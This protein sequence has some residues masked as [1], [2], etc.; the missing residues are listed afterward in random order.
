MNILFI[1]NLPL[2]GIT[3]CYFN[4]IILPINLLSA[5]D[6]F[7]RPTGSAL[8]AMDTLKR[9]NKKKGINV[10]I[11]FV[12]FE[13]LEVYEAGLKKLIQNGHSRIPRQLFF[14]SREQKGSYLS[15]LSIQNNSPNKLVNP[16]SQ[17]QGLNYWKIMVSL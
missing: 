10:W 12:V 1:T 13:I 2:I 5:M 6:I 16:L 4:H 17:D 14:M 3:F 9:P 7:I 15:S 11:G 8:L